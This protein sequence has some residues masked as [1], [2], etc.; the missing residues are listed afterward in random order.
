MA[1]E[2]LEVAERLQHQRQRQSRSVGTLLYSVVLLG[3]LRSVGTLLY[4]VV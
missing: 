2:A 3:V 4:S 1:A